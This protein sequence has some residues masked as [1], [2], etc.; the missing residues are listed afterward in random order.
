MKINKENI[1][2]EKIFDNQVREP[3]LRVAITPYCNFN[4]IYCKPGGEGIRENGKFMSA[5][6]IYE[7]AKIASEVGFKKIKFTGGEP[8]LRKNIIDIVEKTRDIST[9]DRVALV[10]NGFFLSDYAS[11]LKKA[12]LDKIAVSLDAASA[13]KFQEISGKNCFDDVIKGIYAARGNNLPVTINTVLMKRNKDQVDGLIDLAYKTGSSLKFIDFMDI[14]DKRLWAKEYS[15]P[16][17]IASYLEKEALEVKWAYSF[18]G[19][20]TPL[21]KYK[22]K[23]GVE[24]RIKD[25]TIGTNYHESCKSCRNYPCQDALV[26]LRITYDGKLKQCLIRDD[27]LVDVLMP[28]KENKTELVREILQN[29]YNNFAQARF[30]PNAWKPQLEGGPNKNDI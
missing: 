6:E 30:Y 15:P 23:N 9:I 14:G 19:L 16:K 22:L 26:A 11:K 10:T 17:E 8:L 2:R 24:V 27:N 3:H 29:F 12:G 13:E 28:L 20:G 4:C 5:N 7:I 18:G 1:T 25:A 21:P